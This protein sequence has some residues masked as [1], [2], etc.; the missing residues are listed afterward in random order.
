MLAVTCCAVELIGLG[1]RCCATM[2][3]CAAP[4]ASH[5]NWQTFTP[6]HC[7][8]EPSSTWQLCCTCCR[9][10]IPE[11]STVYW[12][13]TIQ[14]A[15]WARRGGSGW[16]QRRFCAVGPA[17]YSTVVHGACGASNEGG[18]ILVSYA[19]AGRQKRQNLSSKS[20]FLRSPLCLKNAW[21]ELLWG[22]K[23]SGFFFFSWWRTN[24][25][26]WTRSS[27]QKSGTWWKSYKL[28]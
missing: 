21:M 12:C 8:R 4:A 19:L 9:C 28:F 15:S 6:E 3:N 22:G 23:F 14:K 16:F 10:C 13:Q 1:M 20:D 17:L 5:E 27:Q 18:S 2:E 24:E 26:R 25:N 7:T 11:L